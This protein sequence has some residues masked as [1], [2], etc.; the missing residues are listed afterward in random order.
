MERASLRAIARPATTSLEFSKEP[1][2]AIC[3]K[4]KTAYEIDPARHGRGCVIGV[5]CAEHEVPGQAGVRGDTGSLEIADFADHDDVRRL[6]QHGTQGCRKR[7]SDFCIYLHL[8]DPS[9]LIFN[10][11]LDSNDF[12][13]RFVDVIETGVKRSRLAGSSR[14]GNQQN[15]IRQLDQALKGFL[16]VGKKSK[17]RQAELQAGFIQ[18]AH[19]DA[20]AVIGGHGRDAKIDRLLLDFYLDATVLWQAFLC[21]THRAGHDLEPAE[22]RSR[23]HGAPRSA[24]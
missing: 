13:V 19:D 8:V 1:S 3:F 7:H 24:T 21:N 11:F 9:H 18:Y 23:Q 22:Y 16:V 5:Q 4:Q 2:R 12:A 14:P 10:R 15:S 6:A 17:L 20:L